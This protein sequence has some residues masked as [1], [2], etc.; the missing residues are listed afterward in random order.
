MAL[1][2]I[3]MSQDLQ[4]SSLILAVDAVYFVITLQAFL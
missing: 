3:E 2:L 4:S 1:I